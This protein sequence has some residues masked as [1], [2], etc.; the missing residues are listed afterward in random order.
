MDICNDTYKVRFKCKK[1]GN[2]VEDYLDDY[3]SPNIYAET[4]TESRVSTG[5]NITCTNCGTEN[6]YSIS[7]DFN[8]YEICIPSD[9]EII[10]E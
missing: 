9:L 2:V 7:V 3:P 1:C 8:D 4:A 5:G 6:D 10:K